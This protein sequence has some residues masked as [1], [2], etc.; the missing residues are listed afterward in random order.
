MGIA[1]SKIQ[2]LLDRL[3]DDGQAGARE[4]VLREFGWALVTEGQLLLQATSDEHDVDLFF[5]TFG[6][7]RGEEP[8]AWV[9]R[10]A[11]GLQQRLASDEWSDLMARAVE[12]AAKKIREDGETGK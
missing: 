10:I 7:P 5:E 8:D 2:A 6:Y 4:G 3:S 11:T 9:E 1:D 12:R